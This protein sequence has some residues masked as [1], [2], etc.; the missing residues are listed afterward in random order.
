MA[1]S[2]ESDKRPDTLTQRVDRYKAEVEGIVARGI[3]HPNC[4]LKRLATP[5]GGTLADRAEFIKLVQGLANA[6]LD[7]E[8]L[9]VVGADQ[10]QRRFF[11]V[12]NARDFDPATL[13]K[14]FEKYL[15]PAPR[16][17]A[18]NSLTTETGERYILIVL[19]PEQ[20]RPVVVV[21][22]ATSDGRTYLRAGDIWVKKDTG[23][24]M[25]TRAD[26]EAMYEKRI[27]QEA[28]TRARSRFKHIQEEFGPALI[29]QIDVPQPHRGLLVGP[30]KDLRSFAELTISNRDTGRLNVMA[31][32]ARERLI[33]EWDSHEV[34]DVGVAESPSKWWDG[35]QEFYRDAFIP[36]LDA[37]VELGLQ[38]IKY[39]GPS[40]WV[41]LVFDV[42][43]D[44]IEK[45][46]N[47][48]RLRGLPVVEHGS[49]SFGRPAFLAYLGVR[50]L[51]TYAVK[52]NRFS[53][54]REIL[55]RFIR[56]FTVE[57][58]SP[59]LIS[60]LFWP[61]AIGGLQD[62]VAGGRNREFWNEHI[63]SAWGFYFGTPDGFLAAAAQ[64]EFILEFNSYVFT[65]L[66]DP[67]IG[68]I[69]QQMP[70][71]SFEYVPDFWASRL[72]DVEPIAS[73]FY[74]AISSGGVPPE[75]AIDSRAFDAIFS[76]KESSARLLLLGEYL[77]HLKKWQA[78]V[79]MKQF[80]RYP[81]MFDWGGP[82][83]QVADAYRES[84]QAKN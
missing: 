24:R 2:E 16:F 60:L 27:D 40:E 50:A 23:L 39:G 76:G 9:I 55:P 29:R 43:V 18:F 84:T 38:T 17:E 70:D 26:L 72:N 48:H 1:T 71:R 11:D 77:T 56:Q 63:Q 4:E 8:R 28:E 53:Y 45:S 83:K 22:E 49:L 36:S 58:R 33:E 14:I 47:F 81:F 52:R 61:F 65:S 80:R 62:T 57:N 10:R 79:M 20:P 64:L 73:R 46:R 78:E 74:E 68:R 44:A 42:L 41:R 5:S 3:E 21:T 54:L 75:F 15:D 7:E 51:A 13:S 32:M 66:R 31:E 25:A 82:L 69:K 19:G 67:Q 6:D 37:L 12:D 34:S 30:K 59:E 35:I